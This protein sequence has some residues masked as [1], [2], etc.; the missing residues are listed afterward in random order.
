MM[1]VNHHLSLFALN[2]PPP[3]PVTANTI[4]KNIVEVINPSNKKND[5]K[6]KTNTNRSKLVVYLPKPCVFVEKIPTK[7]ILPN[8]VKQINAIVGS[9]VF[10]GL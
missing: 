10:I 7:A 2:S 8:I 3:N 6:N 4:F 1:Y 9:T 5:D